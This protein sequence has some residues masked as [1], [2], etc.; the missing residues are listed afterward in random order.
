MPIGPE[1]ANAFSQ[2]APT[3]P[4]DQA[5]PGAAEAAAMFGPQGTGYAGSL[6]GATHEP[7]PQ[8]PMVAPVQAAQDA[9]SAAPQP[10]PLPTQQPVP[11]DPVMGTLK[12]A[13]RKIADSAKTTQEEHEKTFKS[14]REAQEK[15]N[16]A[17]QATN[18]MRQLQQGQEA[19]MLDAHANERQQLLDKNKQALDKKLSLVD[20]A[21]QKYATDVANQKGYWADKDVGNRIG[22]AI[23]VGL[24]G[25]ASSYN[26]TEN[27]A[28][29][30]LESAIQDD[31]RTK[32]RKLA[33]EKSAIDGARNN[34]EMYRQSGLDSESALLATQ[35]D[36]LVA[37]RTRWAA[38]MTGLAGDQQKADAAR[39]LADID[40]KIADYN[41]NLRNTVTTQQVNLM[42][43]E[44]A[45]QDAVQAR[46]AAA[47]AKGHTEADPKLFVPGAGYALDE[48]SAKKARDAKF[49]N[50]NIQEN[51]AKL[52]AIREA[53]H[54]GFVM[55][56]QAIAEAK[57][58]K[59]QV[60]RGM[61]KLYE[62]GV[63]QKFEE[64]SIDKQLPD[65]DTY[66]PLGTVEASYDALGKAVADTT[67]GKMVEFINPSL[68]MLPKAQPQQVKETV[69]VGAKK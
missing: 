68:S 65:A 20:D 50:T 54:G 6:A 37:A 17:A 53:H 48:D 60:K 19:T 51:L 59:E 33:G 63:L 67:Q 31:A 41:G 56:R 18:D 26:H 2:W 5:G 40:A 39:G 15:Q 22:W 32:E 30:L 47:L 55:D 7:A 58:Y 45:H 43:Q 28:M 13:E 3:A 34:Y 16:A 27:G 66:S 8:A 36:G 35:R 57:Q 49:T 25:F 14:Q 42:G 10:P 44:A 46:Q 11:T 1:Y 62:M 24:G 38:A 29:R 23:S 4:Q 61:Q 69:V 52:K 9:P 21:Q 12:A 64:E